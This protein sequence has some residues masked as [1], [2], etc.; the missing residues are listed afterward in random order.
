MKP[1]LSKIESRGSQPSIIFKVPVM[2][3]LKPFVDVFDLILTRNT[4]LIMRSLQ[5]FYVPLKQSQSLCCGTRLS[6]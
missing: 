6:G 1:K 3:V 5:V 2:L 4:L